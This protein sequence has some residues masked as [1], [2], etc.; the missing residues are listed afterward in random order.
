MTCNV[1]KRRLKFLRN[2]VWVLRNFNLLYNITGR[3]RTMRPT[4]F[5][6]T[7]EVIGHRWKQSGT[8]QPITGTGSEGK[9]RT[10]EIFSI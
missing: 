10:R 8:G 6:Y 9:Q 5:K 2:V 1:I 3:Q 4:G 7:G